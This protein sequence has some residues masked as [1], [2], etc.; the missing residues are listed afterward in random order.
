M[1][2][3][4]MFHTATYLDPAFVTGPKAGK[5]LIAGGQDTSSHALSTAEI[6]DPT[7]KTFTTI[8]TST[9]TMVQ[10]RS[11]HTATLLTTGPNAGKV[12]IAGGVTFDPNGVPLSRNDA[13]L[14]DPATNTFTGVASTMVCGRAFHTA[15]LLANGKILLAGGQFYNG[16]RISI[17]CAEVYDPVA[18]TFSGV[19]NMTQ[20]RADHTATLLPN[21]RVLIAG[22]RVTTAGGFQSLN[23]AEFYDPTNAASPFSATGGMT[24]SRYNHTATL[25][26]TGKVLIAGGLKTTF[27]GTTL[28]SLFSLQGAEI[29]D[30]STGM[31]ATSAGTMSVAR[32][33]HT[34]TM[35]KSGRVLIAG[36]RND[37][38][39]CPSCFFSATV[40]NTADLYDPALDSFTPTAL[41][42]TARDSHA[43]VRIESDGT[44]LVTGGE[45]SNGTETNSAEVY[46]P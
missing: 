30:S 39:A 20:P 43:A 36:G 24:D 8:T 16:G 7:A 3:N 38:Q 31:F 27:S 21:G 1:A 32:R 29:Y 34:A 37:S 9:S 13:E 11:G 6:Y 15:T 41:L 23:T 33:L 14:Y 26:N 17:T 2:Y 18:G 28:V 12:L 46:L 22:G 42:S 5:V 19:G 44:V 45:T 4:R 10:P 40:S 35:L 25:L